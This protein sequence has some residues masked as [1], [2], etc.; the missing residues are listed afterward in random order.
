MVV[1]VYLK[2][3]ETGDSANEASLPDTLLELEMM[4]G[5]LSHSIEKL[6]ESTDLLTTEFRKSEGKDAKELYEYIQ[7]N[8]DILRGKNDRFEQITNRI[9]QKK[10][11]FPQKALNTDASTGAGGIMNGS[12]EGHFI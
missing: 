1:E 2:S 4:K 5:E 6:K 12:E 11:I 3:S 7:D 10:G 9:N 8:L